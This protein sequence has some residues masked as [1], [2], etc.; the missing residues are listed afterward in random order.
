MPASAPNPPRFHPPPFDPSAPLLAIE[1]SCDDTCAAVLKLDG[2]IL[3]SVVSSQQIHSEFLGIVPE[4]ASREH[5]RLIL[6]VISEALEQAHVTTDDLVAVA[7]TNGPGLIGS[8]LVGLSAA[9]GLAYARK[10]PIIGV[11]HI[12]AHLMSVLAEGPA[13]PPAVGLVVSGGHTE[14][15]DLPEWGEWSILGATR[16]DAA[17]EAFDKVA[18]LLGLGFPGGPAI[19]R[20][21]QAGSPDAIPFPRAML[22]VAKGGLEFS[23]S[24]LKTAVKIFLD[25]DQRTALPEGSDERAAYVADVAASFQTAVIDVL[26]AKIRAALHRTG[27]D[28]VFVCGGVACNSALRARLAADAGSEGWALRIPSPKYCADNAVM[29]GLAGIH[30]FKRGEIS[31]YALPAM[32]NLDDWTGEY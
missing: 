32:P 4:L 5:L 27:Y 24:G 17:G 18:K 25:G 30:H 9:K 10:I 23:F 15:I 19:D 21:A 11:N 13:E 8:L 22:D 7:V 3:S 12:E 1:S 2:T 26:S 29:V 6:P 14:L 20:V 16:D 31:T 28:R